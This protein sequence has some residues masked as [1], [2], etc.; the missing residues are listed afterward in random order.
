MFE[1]RGRIAL[2]QLETIRGFPFQLLPFLTYEAADQEKTLAW[3]AEFAKQISPK[4]HFSLLLPFYGGL[5]DDLRPLFESLAAQSYTD[6]ELIL[7]VPD[8]CPNAIEEEIAALFRTYGMG[9]SFVSSP[10]EEARH[11]LIDGLQLCR[12]DYVCCL[13]RNLV[14]H[15]Q[16]LF[17]LAK[18]FVEEDPDLVY[19]NE[20]H[21]EAESSQA[22]RFFRKAPQDRY[23]ILSTN[24]LGDGLVMARGLAECLLPELEGSTAHPWELAL[25]ATRRAN[26][27]HRIPLALFLVRE[28]KESAEE[29]KDLENAINLHAE[30]LGL[31]LSRCHGQIE[32]PTLAF[33][34][35]LVE[36]K[37]GIQVIV[38]FR[39]QAE[40]TINCLRSLC[41]QNVFEEIELTLVDNSSKKDEREKVE[42]FVRTSPLFERC[43]FVDDGEY[44]NFARLNNLAVSNSSMPFILF[45]NND[46][47]LDREDSLSVLRSWGAVPDIAVVGG[48][49]RYDDSRL[50]HAGIAFTSIRP[51]NIEHDAQFAFLTRETNAVTF[52]MALVKREVYQEIGGLSEFV[53]PNGF[54][55][56]VFCHQAAKRG[57]R[58]ICVSSVTGI[59]RESRSRG[60]KSEEL[61]LLEMVRQGIPITDLYPDF[62]AEKQPMLVELDSPKQPAF[63]TF[64]ERIHGSPHFY[65]LANRVFSRVF[66]G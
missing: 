61:E 20:V 33:E 38:P 12:G 15:P 43:T 23:S 32:K 1:G 28:A 55:D 16:T 14:F 24:V 60:R 17:I 6:F 42:E 63:D 40:M 51:T 29:L 59:H 52:A 62:I 66:K 49:L 54:G 41:R 50:Q 18:T 30:S 53:C 5:A 13:H 45:L 58:T 19:A 31:E 2:P 26:L 39:N 7:I 4:P 47:E 3:Q 48:R 27:I 10:A 35:V 36:A 37:G 21:V 64:V 44:F 56:A 22:L 57:F 8:R 9:G 25:L 65:S 46:V 34:P 11:L